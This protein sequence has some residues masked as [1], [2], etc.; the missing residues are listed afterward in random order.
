MG[1]K[2]YFPDHAAE[3]RAELAKTTPAQRLT[4]AIEL[5]RVATRLAAAQ[6]RR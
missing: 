3:R 6:R 1:A 5:S 4:E 2:D